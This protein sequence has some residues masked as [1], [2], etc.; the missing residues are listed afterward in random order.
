[1]LK[2]NRHMYNVYIYRIKYTTINCICTSMYSF[3][4]FHDYMFC[5][6]YSI[7]FKPLSSI[8]Y[9]NLANNVAHRL[10]NHMRMR[11]VEKSNIHIFDNYLKCK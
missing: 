5:Y 11:L 7:V 1:M 10:L 4:E 9:F 8:E 2:P 6:I 3:Y